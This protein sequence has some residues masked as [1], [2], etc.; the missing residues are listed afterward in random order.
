ME[1]IKTFI[2]PVITFLLTMFL[3]W[4]AGIELFQRGGA[5]ACSLAFSVLISVLASFFPA[6]PKDYQLLKWM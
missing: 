2:V 1:T 5:Q 3:F 4:Y 6:L